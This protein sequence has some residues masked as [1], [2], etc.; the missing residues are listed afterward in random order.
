MK[1]WIKFSKIV[2][3]HKSCGKTLIYIYIWATNVYPIDLKDDT[4]F[5][6]LQFHYKKETYEKLEHHKL[7]FA[8]GV[9]QLHLVSVQNDH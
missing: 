8:V 4:F 9:I 1:F 6:L 5:K 2:S 7:H 3:L